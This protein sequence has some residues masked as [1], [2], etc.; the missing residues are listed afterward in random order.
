M[1]DTKLTNIGAIEKAIVLANNAND[2]ELAEKLE[3]I[4]VSMENRKSNGGK[5]KEEVEAYNA[6]LEAI[7]DILE[8]GAKTYAEIAKAVA[9]KGSQWATPRIKDLEKAGKVVVDVEKGVKKVR[10]A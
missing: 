9:D 6:S 4:K 10:R 1:A 7:L 2:A 3:K 8:G 5:S